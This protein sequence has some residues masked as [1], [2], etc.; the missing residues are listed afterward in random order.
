MF[1]KRL[2]VLA[3]LASTAPVA[4]QAQP[5]GYYAGLG[6]GLNI[7]ADS[8]V[9][10]SGINVDADFSEGPAAA[11]ALGYR[12]DS[13]F[14]GEFELGYRDNDVDSVSGATGQGSVDSWS[15]MANLRYEFDVNAPIRPYVGAG[16]GG[17][18]VNVDGAGPIGGSLIGDHDTVFAYQGIAGAAYGVTEQI[19]LFGDYRYFATMDPD[20][21][22]NA[23]ASV[24]GEHE[25]HTL[26][27]GL[28]WSFG[29]H[30]EPKPMRAAEVEPPP[31]PEAAKVE[32][33]PPAEPPEPMVEAQQQDADKVI[34]RL[35]MVFFEFDRAEI[36]PEAR[37]VIGTA[38]MNA[39]SVK[40]TRI[41]VTGHAD[42][43][44]PDSYNM[45]LSLRRAESVKSELVTQGIS[46]GD[47]KVVAKGERDPLVQ[48]PDD[49]REP[50]NRR[51]EIV[52]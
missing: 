48:T 14:V 7:A 29:V 27:F 44:G 38:A 52:Y 11:A 6:A 12:Y 15:L 16:L 41:V 50:Q 26:L 20:L 45:K 28:R 18:R 8:N 37:R 1:S 35:Y 25:N 30:G 10:G 4:V 36:T 34:P 13:G 5:T 40:L 47:I 33:E 51:V 3:L 43:S 22:T 17:A 24:E 32:V 49:V 42:R 46:D 2:W 9:S 19:E 21:T 39:R 23:G 31:E